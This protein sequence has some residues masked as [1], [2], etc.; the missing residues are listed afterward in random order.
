MYIDV[1]MHICSRTYT[2]IDIIYHTSYIYIC[3][4]ILCI[5]LLF[6]PVFVRL[7]IA[8]TYSPLR[9]GERRECAC[10]RGREKEKK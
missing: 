8:T 5:L 2:Y 3:F 10:E 4:S 9:S 1:H 7:V 6:S